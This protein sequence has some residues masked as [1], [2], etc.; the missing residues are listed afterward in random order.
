MPV[1]RLKRVSRKQLAE[2]SRCEG[3]GGPIHTC[4]RCHVCGKLRLFHVEACGC[5]HPND[6][7]MIARVERSFGLK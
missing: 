2:A 6:P 5:G 7:A 1:V 4:G 3:C